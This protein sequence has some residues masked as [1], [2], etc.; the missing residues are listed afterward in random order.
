MAIFE[1]KEDSKEVAANRLQAGLLAMAE[2]PPWLNAAVT[3]F[4]VALK[5]D[6][7]CHSAL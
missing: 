1:F 5:H 6:P 2:Q 4:N 3:H 7:N